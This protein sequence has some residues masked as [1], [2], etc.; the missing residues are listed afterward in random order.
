MGKKSTFEDVF[1]ALRDIMMQ[2][3]MELD[4]IR[5]SHGDYHLDT[6]HIMKNKKA[7][8]FGAVKINKNYVSFH[9]MPVYVFPELLQG[10]SP[11]LKR[12]MQGKSCFNF[13]EPDVELF[14]EIALLTKASYLRYQEAGYV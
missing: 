5:N 1:N 13:K 8:F 2:S 10:L 14:K 4:C 9:L 7:L 11:G 12:R 3:A 6:S